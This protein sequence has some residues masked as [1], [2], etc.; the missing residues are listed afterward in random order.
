MP[1]RFRAATAVL[2]LAALPVSVALAAAAPGTLLVGAPPG[3]GAD[4]MHLRVTTNGK[5]MRLVGS[6]AWSYGCGVTHN[7]GVA[8]AATLKRVPAGAIPMFPAPTVLIYGNRF[9]GGTE[10][11][12]PGHR[13]GR[14]TISGRFTGARTARA[15]FSFADPP[16]CGTFTSHVFT[17]TAVG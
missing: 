14:L 16:R 13:Y 10:L 15:S 11:Q 9:S 6:F 17:L 4:R 5:S 2:A 3:F 7:Y 12:R 8:D 1:G